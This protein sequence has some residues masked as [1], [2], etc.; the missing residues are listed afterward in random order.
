M[1]T[2][3]KGAEQAVEN[4]LSV[5]AGE[6]VVIITD[7]ESASIGA[8]LKKAALA[9]GANVQVFMMERTE[10]LPA[11][12]PDKLGKALAQADVSFYSAQGKKGEL[13][14]FRIPMLRCVGDNR[15]LR[16]GHMPGVT[17]EMM[18]T[19]MCADYQEIQRLSRAVYEKVSVA[20]E[21]RVVTD[22]GTNLTVNLSPDLR[23]KIC[24]GNIKADDW[25]NLPDGEVFTSPKDING[26]AVIDGCLG[27]YFDRKFGLLAE[28]PVTIEIKNGRAV[29]ESIQCE[30]EE[31]RQEF[32]EYLFE[33]DETPRRGGEW[34]IGTNTGLTE[35]I[36]NL[37]QDEKFPGV[38]IAFGSPYPDKTGAD[39]NSNGHIDGVIRNTTIFVSG[40]KIMNKGKFLI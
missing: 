21:I 33:T 7:D 36:G 22:N 16:Q 20:E 2:I 11:E 10:G 1:N 25:S 34:A 29:R 4:C 39:W 12:F 37:L 26:T 17:E 35:L 14:S 31:L 32:V 27:D 40:E 6:R 30:N 8:A 24:D 38:H 3:K 15:K 18:V 23:W 9:I 5:Q 13:Q 28:T 19:G